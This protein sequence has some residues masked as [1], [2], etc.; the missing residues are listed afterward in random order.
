[1]GNPWGI[2]NENGDRIK[3]PM[4]TVLLEG[5]EI[6]GLNLVREIPE[7]DL[8]GPGVVELPSA[9][10]QKLEWARGA[11]ASAEGGILKWMRDNDVEPGLVADFTAG[12]KRDGE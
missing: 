12:Y 8:T 9:L 1:M 4:E 5:V 2:A 11:L 10:V 3:H 6:Y 7:A